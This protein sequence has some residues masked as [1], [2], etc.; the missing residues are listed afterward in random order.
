MRS[1]GLAIAAANAGAGGHAGSS[2][3]GSTT[4]KKCRKI[5][6][7]PHRTTG[8]S[9]SPLVG[10][11]SSFHKRDRSVNIDRGPQHFALKAA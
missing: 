2:G 7:R 11:G 4:T 1:T 8:Q 10:P 6:G 9:R 5:S 3:S